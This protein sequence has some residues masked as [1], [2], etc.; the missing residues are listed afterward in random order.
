[1]NRIY[2]N[3]SKI[4][5]AES[6]FNIWKKLSV[7]DWCKILVIGNKTYWLIVYCLYSYS[8]IL[9]RWMTTKLR[10]MHC[11]S[12]VTFSCHICSDLGHWIHGLIPR[13][14]SDDM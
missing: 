10:P 3:I 5:L 4:K 13:T 2:K 11:A 12:E 6:V 14:A 9:L 7:S 8:K 1:M